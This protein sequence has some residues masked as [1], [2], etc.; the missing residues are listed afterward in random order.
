MGK[1]DRP[2]SGRTDRHAFL[3]SGCAD[4]D[5]YVWPVQDFKR[6]VAW[7]KAHALFLSVFRAVRHMPRFVPTTLKSQVYRAADSIPTNIVEGSLAS[8]RK[9][10]A[11]FLDMSIRS[12]GELEH[13][14]IKSRDIGAIPPA[15]WALL[16]DAAVEVRMVTYSLKKRVRE[17]DQQDKS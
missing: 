3:R 13:H 9:E 17:A 11:R 16:N 7:Q 10:F 12:A 4:S 14:L 2:F 1:A 15:T 6:L 8:T 5:L